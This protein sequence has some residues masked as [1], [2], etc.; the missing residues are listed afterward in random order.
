LKIPGRKNSLLTL[1]AQSHERRLFGF[2]DLFSLSKEDGYNKYNKEVALK[3]RESYDGPRNL[4]KKQAL[5][6][7]FLVRLNFQHEK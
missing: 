2:C 5:P 3:L 7:N 6:K 4:D 1:T